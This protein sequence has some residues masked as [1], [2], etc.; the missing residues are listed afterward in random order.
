MRSNL[1]K[2]FYEYIRGNFSTRKSSKAEFVFSVAITFFVFIFFFIIYNN[3]LLTSAHWDLGWIK[4]VIWR[5][6][7][8]KMPID[9]CSP[10]GNNS[11]YI[12]WA[13]HFTPFF[14]LLSLI[15]F[16]WP[17]SSFSWLVMFLA[18]APALLV[19][20]TCNLFF[21][22]E[23]YLFRNK[24][25][26]YFFPVVLSFTFGAIRA[27]AF[28]HYE[29]YF[30]VFI[31]AALYAAIKGS[32]LFFVLS[33]I[34]TIML[35]EDSAF[36]LIILVWFVGFKKFKIFYLFKTTF[37]LLLIP[38]IYLISLTYIQLD[39]PINP[40]FPQLTNLESQYLGKPLLSHISID[41][42]TDRFAKIL[43]ANHFLIIFIICLTIIGI[44][45]KN[46]LT[47]RL[48]LST[49]PYF[50]VSL[51]ANSWV[52]GEMLN[53]ELIPIWTSVVIALLFFQIGTVNSKRIKEFIRTVF[54]IFMLAGLLNGSTNQILRKINLPILDHRML[55]SID[56]TIQQAKS[57]SILLDTNFFV[58]NPN[59][60]SY[61][62]WLSNFNNV[63]PNMCFLHLP[64][65]ETN[66]TLKRIYP[67]FEFDTEPF[68]NSMFKKTCVSA[69]NLEP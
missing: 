9:C 15:S 24:I 19:M 68:E 4:Q 59:L 40:N 55:D 56:Y 36:Y 44:K 34:L 20:L 3:W 16:L 69:K 37:Y 1:S 29:I 30:L 12:S 8:Q 2:N 13:W 6:L 41:F 11:N 58:Y 28:P 39:D 38:T 31:L 26:H 35:K 66:F 10:D 47:V 18:A 46:Y 54:F 64:S 61:N 65:S 33:I 17:F 25:A 42:I 43:N 53:Y 21:S 7:D 14:T 51:I 63:Y 5:N 57:R 62:S 27:M 23:N 60:I 49:F 32:K 67:D 50:I 48:M 22:R 52:K 45:T